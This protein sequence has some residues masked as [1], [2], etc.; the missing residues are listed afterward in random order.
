MSTC[1]A[2]AFELKIF[3]QM[4]LSK[5]SWGYGEVRTRKEK[6]SMLDIHAVSDN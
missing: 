1:F 2:T 5:M 4:F 3:K 6:Y